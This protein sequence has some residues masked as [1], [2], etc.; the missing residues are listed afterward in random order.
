[1]DRD[2]TY[3][4]KK[5]KKMGGGV[6]DRVRERDWEIDSKESEGERDCKTE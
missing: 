4:K 2:G 3:I 6:I 1:M 5:T